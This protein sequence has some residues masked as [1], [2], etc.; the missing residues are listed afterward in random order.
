MDTNKEELAI[1]LPLPELK[2]A[3]D[4][5]CFKAGQTFDFKHRVTT[6]VGDNGAGKSTLVALIRTLFKS[7]WTFS[8]LSTRDYE[9]LETQR[10]ESPITYIDLATDLLKTASQMSS[11]MFLHVQC[12]QQSSGQSAVTQLMHQLQNN[13]SP[14]VIIDEP[15]RGLSIAK[16]YVIGKYLAKWIGEN[17]DVQVLV[18]S[19]SRE[20]LKSVEPLGSFK[21]LPDW[22]DTTAE[23][24]ILGNELFGEMTWSQIK[25]SI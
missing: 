4:F 19:H 1:P 10:T 5:R 11:D 23:K 15:E 14:I 6:I 20:I 21:Q 22:Q 18:I 2:L 25:D 7:E 12:M 16:Q 8:S 9:H 13:S 3:K 17:T 24:Y